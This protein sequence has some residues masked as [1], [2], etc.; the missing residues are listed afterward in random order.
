MAG[1][2]GDGSG[3]MGPDNLPGQPF[4]VPK[5]EPNP[6]SPPPKGDGAHRKDD[7]EK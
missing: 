7:D 4:P 3:G 2:H 6:D 5:E 1:Q